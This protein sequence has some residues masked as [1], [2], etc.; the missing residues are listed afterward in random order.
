MKINAN[1]LRV[2]NVIDLNGKLW[3]I[4]KTQVVQPGKGGA[5]MQ[6]ELRD[7]RTGGK[8]QERFR[9]AEQVER[10]SLEDREFQ[11]LYPEGD[12]FAFMD[13]ETYDQISVSKEIIGES[14]VWLQ[15]GMKVNV[16]LFEGTPLA[17]ELP[18]TVIQTVVEAD[19]A[20][21]G[22][23]AASSYKPGKL[24]NGQRCMIPPHI[25]AGTRIVVNTA[26]GTYLERAKD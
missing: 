13:V 18:Q 19:P 9:S 16:R 23:T 1:S 4:T 21:K 20:V 22:Q 10:V 25:E 26:D 17:V 12:N 15:D 5:F 7:V 3:A 11:V 2:G 8:G 24:D 14:W 6:V